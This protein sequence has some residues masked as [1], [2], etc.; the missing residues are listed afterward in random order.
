MKKTV[1]GVSFSLMIIALTG[2]GSPSGAST[3]L[4]APV[5]TTSTEITEQLEQ[6]IEIESNTDGFTEN[7]EERE[8][9][10]ENSNKTEG[11][12]E[13]ST[14]RNRIDS[15]VNPYTEG[16]FADVSASTPL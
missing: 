12:V 8:N 9:T 11:E 3:E 6:N 1:I 5:E 2:C 16:R 4:A 13:V 14:S 15:K 7:T 10:D